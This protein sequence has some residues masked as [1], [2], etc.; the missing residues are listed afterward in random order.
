MMRE[1]QKIQGLRGFFFFVAWAGLAV[2]AAAQ[3]VAP[4]T[5]QGRV[6]EIVVVFK[7]HFDI[8]YTDMATSIVQRYRTTMIDAALDVADRNEALPESQKF[9]WTIPGWP[10]HKILENWPGQTP[11]R[12]R[13]V[14]QA[15]ER[16]RFVIH[17][18]PFTLHTE[19]LEAEDVARG[20]GYSS[21]ICRELGMPL[22]R[23]AKMTDVPE[24]TWFLPTLLHHAGVEFMHIGCNGMSAPLKVPALFWW[25]GP[26]GSRVLT[27]YSTQYGTGLTPPEDWPCA[28]WLALIHTGDNHGPP[29]PEEVKK[30][31]D[32]AAREYPGVKVRIG[33]LSDF[34]DAVLAEKPT[35]PVVR[36]DAPDT[37]IHGPMSDPAGM[38]MARTVRP[39]LTA[40][41]ALNT[42]LRG[43]GVEVKNAAAPLAAAHEQSLLYGEHTWGGSIGWIKNKLSFGEQF[44]KDRAAGRFTRIEASWDE[45]S[46]YIKQACALAEPVMEENMMALA[47]AAGSG[48][49]VVVFN[50]LPWKRDGVAIVPRNGDILA[51]DVPPLGYK[52]LPLDSLPKPEN[53]SQ[54]DEAANTIE[55]ASFKVTL[56]PAHGTIRSL[57]DKRS[58]R[59]MVDVAAP[60]S[61]GQYLY[62]RFDQDQVFAYCDAYN[63]PGRKRHQDFDKP[64]MPPASEAPYRAA[65]PAEFKVRYERLAA[66]VTAMMDAPAAGN[67]PA[68]TT[69]VTLHSG[70]NY[71]ELTITLHDKKA[72][73]WPEAGWLCLPFK[74]EGPRFRLGR[75][76]SIVDPARDLIPGS[77]RDIFSINTAL[78]MTD[79]GGRGVAVCPL[80][81]PLVSL[82]RPGCWR[83]TPDFVPSKSYVYVNLFN[84]QWDTN[85]RLWNSGTW[86]SRVRIW[87][88]GS[89]EEDFVT[90]ALEAR[91][92][93]LALQGNSGGGKLPDEASGLAL[94]RKG[95][96]VGAFGENPDGAGTLL[97]LWELAG[98]GGKL[99][100]SLPRG[101][102]FKKAQPCDLR[103]VAQG[104]AIAIREGA[105]ELTLAPFA[106]YSV[107]LVK[108]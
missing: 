85:F 64:G 35:L 76:G 41:E 108:N 77:N 102:G 49:R 107:I 53:D 1:H 2:G 38:H 28:T 101:G 4:S 5:A 52:T 80:D 99:R 14:R 96:L 46:K 43:W 22:P 62:E 37:W 58:G 84:N 54:I 105:F 82:E 19:L 74:V 21:A 3:N 100:V 12:A 51:R 72:D 31:L 20:M 83:Y 25:E 6:K 33:R 87:S 13:R 75:L 40:A 27:M 10:M 8:G 45:H 68:V 97:R 47:L 103:G 59:E 32:Q 23:D 61:F 94:S 55:N 106:P 93:L 90:P 92:P 11:E 60:Q 44:E 66:G 98:Q 79:A 57:I 91:Y 78:A 16:G 29:R 9:A 34:A 65:S 71:L 86:T 73:P 36:G 104:E 56:D 67:L 81:K 30:V 39:L 69:R 24:H 89:A 26:D 70:Q 7:T 63:R 48:E 15:L 95:V 17:A 88:V 18:L 42:E 50:P